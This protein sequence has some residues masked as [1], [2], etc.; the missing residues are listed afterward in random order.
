ME[1]VNTGVFS[2]GAAVSVCP[3]GG[4]ASS[5]LVASTW[6]SRLGGLWWLLHSK[7]V[8]FI[9]LDSE[10]LTVSPFEAMAYSHHPSPD[11]F[12]LGVEETCDVRQLSRTGSGETGVCLWFFP[13]CSGCPVS[14]SVYSSPHFFIS[15]DLYWT[16]QHR[17][18][19]RGLNVS[20]LLCEAPAT[21]RGLK[22]PCVQALGVQPSGGAQTILVAAALSATERPRAAF[23]Q[24][25]LLPFLPLR[26]LWVWR[27]VLPGRAVFAGAVQLNFYCN[28]WV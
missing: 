13:G 16:P 12:C 22:T 19:T 18:R 25:L 9:F 2:A 1:E 4:W 27:P 10:I 6:R 8:F 23:P 28:V 26:A 24:P 3:R 21:S 14:W 5:V 15:F 17:A 20:W 11:R 7:L